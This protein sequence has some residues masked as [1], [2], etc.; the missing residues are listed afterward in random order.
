MNFFKIILFIIFA[1]FSF[2]ATA[3]NHDVSQA[4]TDQTVSSNEMLD[5]EEVPLNDPFAG[6]EGQNRNSNIPEEEQEDEMSLY[7][8]KLAGIISG[9]D[10]SYIS[11]VNS[12]GEVIT[13]TLGQFLGK[14]KLVDLRLTEAIFQ[15]EDESYIMLDFNNQIREANEY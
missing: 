7:N 5:E 14:I 4:S 6:N 11:L 13:I 9:K 10:Y 8:F 1:T 12:G 3:D 15:K 2:V